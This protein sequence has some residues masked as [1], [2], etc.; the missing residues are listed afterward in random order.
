VKKE[1]AAV[2]RNREHPEMR[3]TVKELFVIL[4]RAYCRL[5]ENN[6]VSPSLL[7]RRAEIR[8][9]LHPS[10]YHHLGVQRDNVC[11]HIEKHPGHA[12]KQD[13]NAPHRRYPAPVSTRPFNRRNFA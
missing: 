13:T 10:G 12:G 7:H 9:V 5:I 8:R 6:N 11:D 1:L 4:R 3:T 2:A